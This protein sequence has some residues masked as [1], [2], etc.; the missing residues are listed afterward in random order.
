MEH[1][2]KEKPSRKMGLF[3]MEL[4]LVTFHISVTKSLRKSTLAEFVAHS[5]KAEP[6]IEKAVATGCI[7]STGH[8]ETNS[9]ALFSF[10]L[11]QFEISPHLS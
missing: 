5:V 9:Y 2:H 11:I 4:E 6:I 8:R 3:C 10:F 7:E 1:S